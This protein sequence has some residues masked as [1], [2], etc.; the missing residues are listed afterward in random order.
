VAAA[1][2]EV[3]TGVGLSKRI[4][5]KAA[6]LHRV[7]T[8]LGSATPAEDVFSAVT[9]EIGQLLKVDCTVLLRYEPDS[10][11]TLLSMWAGTGAAV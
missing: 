2:A 9:A 5:E 11:V 1:G 8:L 6:A 7:A 4:V 10:A 3:V